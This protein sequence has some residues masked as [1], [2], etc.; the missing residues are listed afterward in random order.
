MAFFAS[1]DCCWAAAWSGVSATPATS[2]AVAILMVRIIGSPG[3]RKKRASVRRGP[4]PGVPLLLLVQLLQPLLHDLRQERDEDL[5][6]RHHVLAFA[7]Q[8]E[9]QEFLHLGLEG[10]ARRLVH[11]DVDVAAH[12]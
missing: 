5:L 1:S 9:R 2:A 6:L 12:R 4:N 8:H 7:A 10:L 3:I 11:V